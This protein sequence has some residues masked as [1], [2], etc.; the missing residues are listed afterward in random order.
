M[1]EGEK[2]CDTLSRLGLVATCNAEGAGKWRQSH[3]DRL[4][5][6]R[7][8]ILP[9]NDDAGRKHA[10]QVAASLQGKATDVRVVALP[11]LADKGDVSDWLAHGGTARL[12][13]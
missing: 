6:R 7:V 13:V 5:G 9:D 8:A 3:A 2:D 4:K 10:E 11:G 12:Q 1:A